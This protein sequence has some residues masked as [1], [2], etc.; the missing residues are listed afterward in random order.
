[1]VHPQTRLNREISEFDGVLN[2]E[3]VFIDIVALVKLE[4]LATGTCQIVRNQPRQE[5]SVRIYESRIGRIRDSERELL[6]KTRLHELCA[7]FKIMAALHNC[8]V[9]LDTPVRQSPVLGDGCGRIVERISARIIV[10]AVGAIEGI[11]RQERAAAKGVL[12]SGG[13]VAG[14]SSKGSAL[15]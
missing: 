1:M 12:I 3:S 8:E 15:G 5:I 2:I 9:G 10:H 6:V 11:K 7:H 13:K 4:R 14:V